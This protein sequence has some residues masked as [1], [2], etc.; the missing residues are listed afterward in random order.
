M[1]NRNEVEVK[2]S[3]ISELIE[4]FDFGFHENI[5]QQEWNDSLEDTKYW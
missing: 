3:E 1:E 2:E 4:N 5:T